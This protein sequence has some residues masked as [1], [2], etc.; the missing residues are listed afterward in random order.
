MSRQDSTADKGAVAD[1]F[2][3]EAEEWERYYGAGSASTI[4]LQNILTRLEIVLEMLGNGPGRVLDVGSA[5][6]AVS[7]LLGNASPSLAAMMSPP[8]GP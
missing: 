8:P 7:V 5:A 4:S 3:A 1:R 2:G 6:G